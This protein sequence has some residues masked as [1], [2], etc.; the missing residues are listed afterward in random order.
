M[1]L[2]EFIRRKPI[3]ITVYRDLSIYFN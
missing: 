2:I 3:E 1:R